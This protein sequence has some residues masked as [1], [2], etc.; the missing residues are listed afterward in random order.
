MALKIAVDHNS[1]LRQFWQFPRHFFKL[2]Y[3]PIQF[4]FQMWVRMFVCKLRMFVA[5]LRNSLKLRVIKILAFTL[6]YRQ[7]AYFFSVFRGKLLHL[8]NYTTA[9]IAVVA[10]MIHGILFSLY[11][12]CRDKIQALRLNNAVLL[13]NIILFL[14]YWW[15]IPSSYECKKRQFQ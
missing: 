4:D 1:Y 7:F 9:K 2:L 11:G 12:N 3:F 15:D 13:N 14:R 10:S 5:K 6:D 8:E